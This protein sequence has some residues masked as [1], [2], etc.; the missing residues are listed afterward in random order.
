MT[1]I[2]WNRPPR[3]GHLVSLAH[4]KE[5]MAL[6]MKAPCVHAVG[7]VA[8][9]HVRAVLESIIGISAGRESAFFL[10]LSITSPDRA[11]SWPF[12]PV[13][14]DEQLGAGC[15]SGI[16]A[17]EKHFEVVQ[18]NGSLGFNDSNV[19]HNFGFLLGKTQKDRVTDTKKVVSNVHVSLKEHIEPS[20][21]AS[22]SSAK[23]TPTE[24]DDCMALFESM[25][26]GQLQHRFQVC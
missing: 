23:R 21:K 9:G 16:A 11:G 10:W 2:F 14:R 4:G 17:L 7:L 15:V 25:F 26:G 22:A 8:Q 20:D 6:L 3:Q 13:R 24:E 19:F 5:Q 1:R 18:G 12:L